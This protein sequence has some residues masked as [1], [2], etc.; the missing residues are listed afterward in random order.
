MA[1]KTFREFAKLRGWALEE[2]NSANDKAVGQ[3]ISQLGLKNPKIIPGATNPQ[4]A[5][6]AMKTPQAKHLIAKDPALA[7][8]MGQALTGV[9]APNVDPAVGGQS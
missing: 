6:R 5:A 2:D 7:G 1:M 9:A 8:K 4:D 3:A